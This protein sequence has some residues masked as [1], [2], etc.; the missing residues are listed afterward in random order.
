MTDRIM[1]VLVNV[2][3]WGHFAMFI[4]KGLHP[5]TV[6]SL[7]YLQK[8]WKQLWITV[9][10]L[11]WLIFITAA[12]TGKIDRLWAWICPAVC[13]PGLS[14]MNELVKNMPTYMP[15]RGVLMPSSATNLNEPPAYFGTT[16]ETFLNEYRTLDEYV[17]S[18]RR[19]LALINSK[20]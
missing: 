12:G 4:I 8:K 7:A 3:M 6:H 2:Y 15:G 16:V 5:I 19:Y 17:N 10:V 13:S 20:N 9:I 14:M 1:C 18:L 11:S